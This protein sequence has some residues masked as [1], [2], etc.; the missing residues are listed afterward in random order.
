MQRSSR[1]RPAQQPE[2]AP[3]TCPRVGS[4]GCG[5]ALGS[6]GLRLTGIIKGHVALMVALAAGRLPLALGW[7]LIVRVLR[8]AEETGV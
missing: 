8:R 1:E 7:R 6:E 2:A 4:R 5:A 3:G